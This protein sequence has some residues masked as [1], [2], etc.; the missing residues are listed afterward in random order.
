MRSVVTV[1]VLLASAPALADVLPLRGQNVA[2]RARD[3]EICEKL[4]VGK[5]GFD[6]GQNDTGQ[7]RQAT[8]NAGGKTDSSS[9]TAK[10]R[11]PKQAVY[12]RER[13]ACLV[14]RGYKVGG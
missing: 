12:E 5:S 13:S 6:P 2:E 1:A 9:P 7:V 4:A 8:G 14:G 3:I 10:Q 11:S